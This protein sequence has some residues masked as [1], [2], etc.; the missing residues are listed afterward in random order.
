MTVFTESEAKSNLIA[1]LD[2][3]AARG[4]AAIR[5]SDGREFV[6]K[7]APAKPPPSL[8]EQILA[9]PRK[10]DLSDIAGTWVEDPAFDEAIEA[11]RQIDP[12]M[13]K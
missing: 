11:Q 1:L 3:A 9:S 6:V 12:D 4:E 10:R 5:L 8:K 7:P 13:W 2:E